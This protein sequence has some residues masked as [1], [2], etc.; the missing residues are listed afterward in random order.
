VLDEQLTELWR[1]IIQ[2]RR[3]QAKRREQTKWSVG[4]LQVAEANDLVDRVVKLLSEAIEKPK[5]P[6]NSS[7]NNNTLDPTAI[8]DRAELNSDTTKEPV[9]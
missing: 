5:V 6:R 1:F 3:E 8:D 9:Q 4:Y 2:T 7:T